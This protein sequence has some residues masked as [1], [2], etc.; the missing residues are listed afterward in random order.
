[1]SQCTSLQ[2]HIS[3]T[4]AP[5]QRTSAHISA[6]S[7]QQ[8]QGAALSLVPAK[9]STMSKMNR[10]NRP[11]F[12]LFHFVSFCFNLFR[13]VSFWFRFSILFHFCFIFV[14]FFSVFF[15]YLLLLLYKRTV[16]VVL[17]LGV[18]HP[19]PWGEQFDAEEV[20][21]G[22]ALVLQFVARLDAENRL[23]PSNATSNAGPQDLNP[24]SP[25]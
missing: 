20:P 23:C 24:S 13:C 16:V 6:T 18:H 7:A 9:G 12:I 21:P 11:S 8:R 2:R 10:V 14:S 5:H 4:S 3:T 17:H 1:M 22:E 19:P 15:P 25:R